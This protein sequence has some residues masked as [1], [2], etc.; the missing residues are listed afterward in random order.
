M[1]S[2]VKTNFLGH[3]V[4]GSYLVACCGMRWNL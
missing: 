3:G 4:G 1:V 2:I